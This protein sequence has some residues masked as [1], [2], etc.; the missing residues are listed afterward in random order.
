MSL[1]V[2]DFN[3]HHHDADADLLRLMTATWLLEETENNTRTVHTC[4]RY[5]YTLPAYLP[6]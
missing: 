3:L 5:G 6:V 1:P 2:F 4:V